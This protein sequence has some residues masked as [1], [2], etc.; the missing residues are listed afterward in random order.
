MS[1]NYVND[2]K[3]GSIVKYTPSKSHVPFNFPIRE[4]AKR[5]FPKE[6]PTQTPLFNSYKEPVKSSPYHSAATRL[7]PTYKEHFFERY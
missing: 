5:Y 6:G 3:L 1:L 4:A 7:E 2:S